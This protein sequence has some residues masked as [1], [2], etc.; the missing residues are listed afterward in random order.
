MALCTTTDVEYR[1]GGVSFTTTEAVLVGE[2]IDAAQ[3]HMER[4]A[5]RTLETASRTE[6]FDAPDS[7][8]IW[9]ENTPVT[10]VGSVTVDGTTL[11]VTNDFLFTAAGR[12]TRVSRGIPRHWATRKVQ[13]VVVA[14][15][16]GFVTVPE[17][18]K[19]ICARVA[20]R[21]YQA[22][23]AYS[24][25]PAAAA[26]VR[27]VALAGSD[28]VTFATSVSDVTSSVSLT[29]DEIEAVRYYRNDVLA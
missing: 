13:T 6:T 11:T 12:V 28:S 20:A 14:Y 9:L 4:I 22:G 19:D 3:G 29:D 17:D 7:P 21:A 8:F 15:T 5:A 18:L 26:G 23:E 16:G 25:V 2:L 27:Q 1:L 10:A 24:S